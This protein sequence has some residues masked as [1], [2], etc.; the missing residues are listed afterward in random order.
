MQT[1]KGGGGS[2]GES[3]RRELSQRRRVKSDGDGARH[4]AAHTGTAAGR[5]PG[6]R[7][8]ERKMRAAPP[9]RSDEWAAFTA[10]GIYRSQSTAEG[11][12]HNEPTVRGHAVRPQPA[13]GPRCAR[14]GGRE[15]RVTASGMWGQGQPGA[16]LGRTGEDRKASSQALSGRPG[17]IPHPVLSS[18]VC[19]PTHGAAIRH[20]RATAAAAHAAARPAVSSKSPPLGW[21]RWN[22]RPHHEPVPQ[23]QLICVLKG[24][25]H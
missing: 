11:R 10:G 7:W 4:R 8:E 6:D 25:S 14:A 1:E 12:P 20:G 21:G 5:D 3:A 18:S 16:E 13:K 17:P 9:E 22:D 19:S 15:R 24:V 23:L 2:G